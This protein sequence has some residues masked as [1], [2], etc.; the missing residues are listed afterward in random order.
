VNHTTERNQLVSAGPGLS[1]K[2]AI[3]QSTETPFFW[4]WKGLKRFPA[5]WVH[6][7]RS[8]LSHGPEIE[9]Q[10]RIGSNSKRPGGCPRPVDN[11]SYHIFALYFSY[12]MRIPGEV[13]R[14][15]AM[16]S[17]TIPI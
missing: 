10:G 15:S 5:F 8:I 1:T 9:N 13:A 3:S 12:H 2:K 6:P 7:G 17:L 14:E 11:I 16:M 4:P